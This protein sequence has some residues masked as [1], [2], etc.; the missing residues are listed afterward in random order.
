[1]P[2]FILILNMSLAQSIIPTHFNKSTITPV[3]KKPRPA[4]LNDYW[5]DCGSGGRAG[6]PLIERLAVG[7]SIHGSS[8]LH[9]IEQATEHQIG[10]EG[11][12]IGVFVCVNELD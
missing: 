1:M 10:P 12:A 4:C 8:S 5:G 7:G 3:P 6:C 2:V 11:I 9:G